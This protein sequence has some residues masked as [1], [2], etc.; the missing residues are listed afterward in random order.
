MRPEDPAPP[1]LPTLEVQPDQQ[2]GTRSEAPPDSDN[3]RTG[4]LE[5]PPPAADDLWLGHRRLLYRKPQEVGR[6]V[7]ELG[8]QL[9]GLSRE[10]L[11]DL[12]R[13]LRGRSK[14]LEAGGV[15]NDPKPAGLEAAQTQAV[16]S[17]SPACLFF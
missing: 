2:G 9:H 15:D 6:M 12:G 7:Q 17:A 3:S 4:C 1:P 10:K 13:Q 8:R 16:A 5:P 11:R 14:L